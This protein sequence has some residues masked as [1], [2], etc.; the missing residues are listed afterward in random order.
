MKPISNDVIFIINRTLRIGGIERKIAGICKYLS[1]NGKSRGQ[2]IYLLLNEKQPVDSQ[3]GFL[4]DIVK[5]SIVTVLYKPQMKLWGFE[6]PFSLFVLVKTLTLRPVVI[7]AFLRR[8]SIIS[9]AV[10]YIFWWR[11]IKVV[12]SDD[13][14]GSLSL[15]ADVKKHFQNY[16]IRQLIRILYSRADIVSC[17]S[18]ASK[19]DLIGNFHV[20]SEIITVNKNWVLEYPSCNDH[21]RRIDLIYVGRIDREKHLTF[22]VEI[23]HEVCKTIPT[24]STCIVGWGHDLENVSRLTREYGLYSRISFVGIQK[25]V[26]KYLLDSKIFCLTSHYEGLPLA[27]LEAMAHGLPVITTSYLGAEELV[28]NGKTGYICTRREEY[29][30]R[31]IQLLKDEKQR[32]MMGEQAREYVRTHHEEENLKGFL[33]LFLEK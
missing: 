30:S 31:V 20:P 18:E 2:M 29:V 19:N 21:R 26:G 32:K 16:V 14:V 12:I 25:D 7:L 4:F 28:Q 23:V 9:V 22:F 24:V 8:L 6:F 27:A 15:R 13:T 1:E 3:E 10:K 5:D 33:R 11:T 17:P